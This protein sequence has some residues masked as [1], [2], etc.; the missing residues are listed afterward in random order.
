MLMNYRPMTLRDTARHV[1][2]VTARALSCEVA[3]IRLDYSDEPV[4]EGVGFGVD[5]P[6]PG[7]KAS[8]LLGAA[9]RAARQDI[10]QAATDG[11]DLFGIAV[12]SRMTVPSRQAR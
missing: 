2:E 12:A 8:A 7:P 9:T 5:G 10:A 1:A 3:A 6:V 4:I 11:P